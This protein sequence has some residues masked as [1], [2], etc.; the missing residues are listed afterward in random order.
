[1]NFYKAILPSVCK[2]IVSIGSNFFDTQKYKIFFDVYTFTSPFF[3][4][5]HP[6]PLFFGKG[7]LAEN[8]PL[9]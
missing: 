2:I 5:P 9:F 4:L 3:V 1:M 8:I 7:E 6:Q